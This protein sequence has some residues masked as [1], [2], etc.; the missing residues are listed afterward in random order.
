MS[1]SGSQPWPAGERSI[2][3]WRGVTLPMGLLHERAAIEFWSGVAVDVSAEET[4]TDRARAED[5]GA[6]IAIDEAM[7]GADGG[8]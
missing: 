1:T 7:P 6:T 5:D 4:A 2:R 3:Q 8:A